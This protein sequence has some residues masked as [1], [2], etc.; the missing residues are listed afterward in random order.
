M[1]KLEPSFLG[2]LEKF[3]LFAR[4]TNQYPLLHGEKTFPYPGFEPETFGFQVGS[5]TN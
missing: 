2:L 3:V 1:F 4:L 5:A